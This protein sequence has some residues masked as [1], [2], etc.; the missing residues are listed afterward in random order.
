M[1]YTRDLASRAGFM[2]AESRWCELSFLGSVFKMIH[3]E[4]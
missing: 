1:D 2:C 3:R 4:Y